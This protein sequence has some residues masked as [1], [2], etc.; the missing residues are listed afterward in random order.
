L[1]QK[2]ELVKEL[3]ILQQQPQQV[4]PESDDQNQQ[5]NRQQRQ[6]S[7]SNHWLVDLMIDRENLLRKRYGLRE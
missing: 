7:G 2:I 5:Q 3:A 1:L 4:K 6:P